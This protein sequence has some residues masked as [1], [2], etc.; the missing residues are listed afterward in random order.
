MP[1]FYFSIYTLTFN[2]ITSYSIFHLFS[3]DPICFPHLIQI[4]FKFKMSLL[5]ET[6]ERIKLAWTELAKAAL[7]DSRSLGWQ[8]RLNRTVHLHMYKC[9]INTLILSKHSHNSFFFRLIFH[10]I[11]FMA[12]PSPQLMIE[13]EEC[14]IHNS[15]IHSFIYKY[16]WRR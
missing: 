5:R 2:D 9:G 4:P 11:F 8:S 13:F 16:L 6:S 1:C 3:L 14:L 7:T 12:L 15:F 10:K